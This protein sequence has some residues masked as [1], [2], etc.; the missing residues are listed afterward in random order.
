LSVNSL[1]NFGVPGIAGERSPTLQPI[2]SNKFRI[3]F[4]DFGDPGKVSP[5]VCTQQLKATSLPALTFGSAT[6]Y[7]YVSTIYISTRAEWSEMDI[8][9]Y[10]DITTG[11]YAV[12][13]EQM[14]KQQNMFDQ[15]TSRAGEN[16]KFEMDLDILAGGATAGAAANDPNILRRYSYAGCWIV[17]NTGSPM[18]YQTSD[19]IDFSI[20]VRYDNVVPFDGNGVQLGMFNDEVQ[21]AARAGISST[22]IGA[23]AGTGV[24][25]SSNSV[26]IGGAS[27][28]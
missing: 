28:I 15:T 25:I 11:V 12:M 18:Q 16:Y 4:Y 27:T 20:T 2:L 13:Y 14:A 8:T 1:V 17:K 23:A 3:T 22:G 5:Y 9:F 26:S 6:L 10:D 7:A 24:S 21:I 19:P